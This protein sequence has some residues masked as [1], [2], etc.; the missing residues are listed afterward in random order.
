MNKILLTQAV[1]GEGGSAIK[2]LISKEILIVGAR[3]WRNEE[4]RPTLAFF[5]FG[6]LPDPPAP[7][8]LPNIVCF[9]HIY[10]FGDVFWNQNI[11]FKVSNLNRAYYY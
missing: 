1:G 4:K 10:V 6:A 8:Y 7:P 9:F 11:F 3:G 5:F 2:L